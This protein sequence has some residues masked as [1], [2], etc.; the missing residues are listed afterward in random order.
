MTGS[1]SDN[2]T[3]TA[4]LDNNYAWDIV[5]TVSDLLGT[6]TFNSHISRGM[7][8]IYFDRL[9]S[10]VGVNCFPKTDKSLEVDGQR[11]NNIK[12]YRNVTGTAAKT[13]SPQNSAK[14]DVTDDTVTQYWDG[15]IVS[16]KVPVAGHATY[17]TVFQ[18]N[19]LG[20]V[21]FRSGAR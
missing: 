11:L 14:W 21:S 13:T 19:S 9:R 15:M 2:V 18:I 1:L 6:A 12:M 10:S 20:Y 17:G 3:S 7:P 4:N 16:V 5:F 8:I